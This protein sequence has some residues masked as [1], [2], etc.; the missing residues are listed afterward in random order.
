MK[1]ILK[2]VLSSFALLTLI[3]CTPN[4]SDTSTETYYTVTF[5][6]YDNSVLQEIC[7]LEGSEATYSGA[8]PTRA[9]DDEFTYEFKGWDKDLTSI[10]EDVTT[11]AEYNYTAKENWGSI[12]WF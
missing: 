1:R 2:L 8:T 5:V 3:A 7:V 9:E 10:T 11:M 6:N 12:I 4:N